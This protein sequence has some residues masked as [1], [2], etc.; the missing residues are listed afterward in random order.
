MHVVTV[1]EWLGLVGLVLIGV[2]LV[3]WAEW[4]SGK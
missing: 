4:R 1:S 3:E 2:G